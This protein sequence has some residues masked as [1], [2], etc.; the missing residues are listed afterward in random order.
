[1]EGIGVVGAVTPGALFIVENHP[2]REWSNR[3]GGL[4]LINGG[5]QVFGLLLAALLG[6]YS[7]KDGLLIAASLAAMAAL[8]GLWTPETPIAG[9]RP[10]PLPN[11]GDNQNHESRT[12]TRCR[13]KLLFV[14][15][16]TGPLTDLSPT[17]K[18]F[19][20][21]WFLCLTG[22]APME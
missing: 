2:Q 18:R 6:Q 9:R 22:S 13:F 1:M 16:M 17:F 4:Q 14:K 8:P 5:G 3:I 19:M 10:Q 12:N 20:I 15:A 7:L 21:I 11:C